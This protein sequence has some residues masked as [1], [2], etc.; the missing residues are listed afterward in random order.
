M[1]AKTAYTHAIDDVVDHPPL[2]FPSA[3]RPVF[4][5]RVQGCE[6]QEAHDQES[7]REP[8][9]AGARQEEDRGGK[10]VLVWW[11]QR[12][13]DWSETKEEE[14]EEGQVG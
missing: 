14:A 11:C 10:R 8:D 7:R 13:H 5:G 9:E 3:H 1:H 2:P 4:E 12:R 6:A